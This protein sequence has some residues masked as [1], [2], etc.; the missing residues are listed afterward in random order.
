MDCESVRYVETRLRQR[1]SHT[2]V[3][4]CSGITFWSVTQVI[5]DISCSLCF[6]LFFPHFFS[7]QNCLVAAN[8]ANFWLTNWLTRLKNIELP[9]EQRATVK[10]TLCSHSYTWSAL[11]WVAP[12][13]TLLWLYTVL[14]CATWEI[15]SRCIR[16]QKVCE[17]GLDLMTLCLA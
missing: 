13:P 5:E 14:L 4:S 15:D 16:G 10:N 1:W 3:V 17:L 7:N 9:A 12:P 2:K 6:S 11:G 8:R